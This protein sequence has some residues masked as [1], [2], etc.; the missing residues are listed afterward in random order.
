MKKE[1][2]LFISHA[3]EDK[4]AVVKPLADA[5]KERGVKVWY[6]E[7][8]LKL[9]DSLSRSIDHG[10]IHS[11]FGLVVLSKNFFA[12]QWTEYELQSLLSRATSGERIILPLWHR[13]GKEDVRQYSLY[14]ADLKALSTELGVEALSFEIMKRVRPDILDSH[15]RIHMARKMREGPVRQVEVAPAELCDSGVRHQTFP[16]YLVIACRLI[17]EVFADI[18]ST[19][20]IDMVENFAKDWDYEKEFIVWSAMAN[21]YVQFIRETRCDFENIAKKKEAFKLLLS[22]SLSG[23][24]DVDLDAYK[25][26]N[27]SE[28]AYLVGCYIQN[29]RHILD[30][31][32]RM[33]QPEG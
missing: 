21:A 7:F 6:D 17:E 30:M 14:L 23:E 8:E 25:L 9:G 4:S 11:N 20:Y 13:I 31:V 10:L 3:S 32:G 19:S 1:W 2:D 12:K 15:V 24:F 16:S 29:V 28:Q 18:I 27:A 5:L 22:Y 26:L 33:A